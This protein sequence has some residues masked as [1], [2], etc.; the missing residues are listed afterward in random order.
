MNCVVNCLNFTLRTTCYL[1][2]GTRVEI[3]A[4]TAAEIDKIIKAMG[5]TK[6]TLMGP[7]S[8]TE[9]IAN[10]IRQINDIE[11]YLMGATYE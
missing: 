11:I 7:V 9:K 8:M 2:D 10:D 3:N 4:L 6:L 1:S 5:V